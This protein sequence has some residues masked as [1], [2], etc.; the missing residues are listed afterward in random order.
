MK[1]A[2]SWVV[3]TITFKGRNTRYRTVY[4]TK[5]QV[6]GGTIYLCLDIGTSKIVAAHSC[7]AADRVK[8][9]LALQVQNCNT[10]DTLVD[11]ARLF[12]VLFSF[13]NVL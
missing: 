2:P 13:L 9:R 11:S 6:L 8:Q 3:S 12:T 1:R 7:F 5:H 10:L 4:T